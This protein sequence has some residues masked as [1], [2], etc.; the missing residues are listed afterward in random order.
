MGGQ[1]VQTP[2]EL[3][4]A[5]PSTKVRSEDSRVRFRL[6]LFIFD[7]KSA[8]CEASGLSVR[9]TS[10]SCLHEPCRVI[11]PKILATEEIPSV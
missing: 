2:D 9:I 8:A 4:Q 6:Y 3:R 5:Q 1:E 10:G 7:E 11:G